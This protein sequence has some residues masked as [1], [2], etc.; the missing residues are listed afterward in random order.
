MAFHTAFVAALM[1]GT[2]LI[3]VLREGIQDPLAGAFWATAACAGIIIVFAGVF[4]RRSREAAA[5]WADNFYYLGLLFT[6]I[7]LIYVLV[8]VFG[9]GE[10]GAEDGTQQIIG[11]FGIAL[12]S[13][14]VGIVVRIVLLGLDGPENETMFGD[15]A[16]PGVDRAEMTVAEGAALRDQV[17]QATDALGHFTRITQARAD[18]ARSHSERVLHE[19]N[20]RVDDMAQTRLRS[21]DEVESA[22]AAGTERVQGQVDGMIAD[23]ERK[24]AAAVE[25][26]SDAW[27]Q[28]ALDVTKGAEDARRQVLATGERI[29]EMLESVATVTDTLAPL[30]TEI[31]AASRAMTMLDGAAN[32]ATARLGSLSRSSESAATEIGTARRTAADQLSELHRTLSSTSAAITALNESVVAATNGARMASAATEEAQTGSG[33]ATERI[34]REL[35]QAAATITA[36]IG[37]V[38][39][40]VKAFESSTTSLASLEE[41]VDRLRQVTTDESASAAVQELA[42][43]VR[44]YHQELGR[45]MDSLLRAIDALNESLGDHGESASKN[46]ALATELL[47]QLKSTGERRFLGIVPR[48]QGRGAT[49]P[50]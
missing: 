29:A 35:E 31:G 3:V 25:R 23:A 15:S 50:R 6:L 48:R 49:P 1:I 24:L 12:V 33:E 18:R 45:Q 17:R 28:L 19:F 27:G 14:V 10:G 22:W 13:T 4:Y 42:G 34:G 40:A 7:S 2:L 32:E 44:D 43:A 47:G 39:S 5:R 21:L 38:V 11:N 41:I 30:T 46:A 36:A 20:E 16:S 9:F 37:S 26:S 8:R